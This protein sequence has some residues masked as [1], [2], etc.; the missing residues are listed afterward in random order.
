[1][2]D[3]LAN[4]PEPVLRVLMFL[5]IFGTMA[6]FELVAPRLARPE[7]S[8]ALRSRRWLTNIALVVISTVILRVVFPAAAVG[9]AAWAAASGVGVFNMLIVPAWIAGLVAFLVLD[10]AVWLEHVAS[11]KIPILWA[12][13]R[14]HHSDSGFDVSTALRFHPLE[15]VL[16]MVWKAGVVVALGAPVWAVLVFEIVL[17]G[18]ATFNHANARLPGSLDRALRLLI[19]TPDMHRTHHSVARAEM[20]SNYGFNLSWWDR[21]F[22]TY[23]H[24]PAAGESGVV[25]GLEEFRA[26]PPRSLA[27]LLVLPFRRK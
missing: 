21:I 20:D 1:M 13:H 24:G 14:I 19:V 9:A 10:F 7:M 5:A 23:R 12:I 27:T 26:K 3:F 22:S 2:P 11:H 16:S 17:N 4:I 8:G 15:I 25:I 6:A 18:A